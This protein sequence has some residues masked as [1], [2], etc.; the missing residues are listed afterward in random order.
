MGM[1]QILVMMTAVMLVGC[2]EDTR[3]AVRA[4]Q[5]DRHWDIR[6]G[7]PFEGETPTNIISAQLG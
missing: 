2:G 1:K 3:K 7:E 6:T 5:A 4:S